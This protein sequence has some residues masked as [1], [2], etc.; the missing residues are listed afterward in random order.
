MKNVDEQRG[1]FASLFMAA[2]IQAAWSNPSPSR[3]IYEEWRDKQPPD[4]DASFHSWLA[5][6]AIDEA[7]ALIDALGRPE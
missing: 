7:E 3:K 2:H 6:Y 1:Y 5:A 4:S